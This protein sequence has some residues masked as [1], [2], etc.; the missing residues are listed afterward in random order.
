MK[1]FIKT[2]FWIKKQK[3]YKSDLDLDLYVK[4]IVS[5]DSS[6]EKSANKQDSLAVDGTGIKYPTV[7]AVNLAV[8]DINAAI[9]IINGQI[10]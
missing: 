6:S 5:K 4:D 10:I 7:D 2:G 3:G 9:D 1:T 8:G